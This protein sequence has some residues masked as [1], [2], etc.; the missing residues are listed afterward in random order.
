MLYLCKKVRIMFQDNEYI[1]FVTY[2]QGKRNRKIPFGI[3]SQ[4]YKQ[5]AIV[6][7]YSRKI[8]KNLIAIEDKRYFS[9]L[10]IDIK[11]ISRALY[12]NIKARRIIQGG[13]TITQQL[14]RN[15]FE[16]HSITF[17]RKIKEILYAMSLE[18]ENTKEEI[19]D[20]Y[21][22]NIYWG[23]NL[24]GI[25]AASLYYF[26]KEPYLLSQQEQLLLLT[27]LRGPNY[28]IR[29][30]DL[31][32]K[33]YNLL[34]EILFKKGIISKNVYQNNKMWTYNFE[35]NKLSIIP[36]S[37]IPYITKSINN[38][39]SSIL[40][41]LNFDL[42][43]FINY[44]IEKSPYP[45]S[46]VILQDG[47]IIGI[48]SKYGIDY[49][50]TFHSNIGSTLKPFLYTFYRENGVSKEE[51]FN[52]ITTINNQKW[53]VKEA[54]LPS[55]SVLN[56]QEALLTSNNNAFINAANKIG[57]NN[58]LKF[59]ASLLNKEE[60]NI[61]PSSILGAT[62]DGISLFELTKLYA[63]FFLNNDD[64]FKNE[65]K[66]LLCQIAK[67]K[68]GI[69]INNL[70]LKTG[71]TNGNKERFAILGNE[72]IVLGIMR[73][74][75]SINDYSKDGSFINSIK[76]IARNIFSPKKMYTWM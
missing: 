47:K 57:M 40:T 59:I 41:S 60:S 35:Y 19:L 49:P 67:I 43:N 42:Q 26:A 33:R 76:N 70:F 30:S 32:M 9:H 5:K 56:I 51:T 20:L 31:C 10:G 38:K 28:Y 53:N 68:L 7:H 65:C 46:I 37:V 54:E 6:T 14:A 69:D 74:E 72:K 24:Y 22:N 15:L 4:S 3:V 27:I 12:M 58:V 36:P 48:N 55:K 73:Q 62:S 2:T 52:C 45:I 11:S 17:H 64:P 34:N 66:Q 39:K 71:T 13:S 1:G 8:R 16:D 21:F 25:R 50:L 29:H 61:H 18:R 75:N 44:T 63:D 23:K